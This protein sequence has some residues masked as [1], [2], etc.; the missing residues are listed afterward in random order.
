[1]AKLTPPPKTPPAVKSRWK[2]R[3]FIVL[4]FV[5]GM[6]I[7]ASAVVIG[8]AGLGWGYYRAYKSKFSPEKTQEHIIERISR[9]LKLSDQQR[10][11]L[12]PVARDVYQRINGIRMRVWPEIERELE[13]GLSRAKPE[14]SAEQYEKLEK[15]YQKIKRH[16]HKVEK[17]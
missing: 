10:K 8:G 2:F 14:L 1:M 3:L 4:I 12:E 6:A 15:R 5:A 16:W 7:G 17:D 9:H 13:S 11:T